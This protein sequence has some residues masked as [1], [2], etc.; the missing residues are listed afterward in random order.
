MFFDQMWKKSKKTK[1]EAKTYLL[2]DVNTNNLYR[3]KFPV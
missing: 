3:I 2:E 1:F